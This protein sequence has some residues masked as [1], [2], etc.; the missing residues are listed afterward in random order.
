MNK[1][2]K[3]DNN[4]DLIK[5][6]TDKEIILKARS[7]LKNNCLAYDDM[8]KREK[9]TCYTIQ[10]KEWD[11]IYYKQAKEEFIKLGHEPRIQSEDEDF[12]TYMLPD[13]CL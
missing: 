9:L 4:K 2:K 8:L 11:G 12:I 5:W 13:Y 3:I 10:K 6:H 1:Q 7:I